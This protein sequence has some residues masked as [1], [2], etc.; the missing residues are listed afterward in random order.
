MSFLKSRVNLFSFFLSSLVLP[1]CSA[2]RAWLSPFDR[3]RVRMRWLTPSSWISFKTEQAYHAWP[4]FTRQVLQNQ[5]T[6]KFSIP[7]PIVTH[8]AKGETFSCSVLASEQYSALGLSHPLACTGKVMESHSLE[9]EIGA[10]ECFSNAAGN[11]EEICQFS[12]KMSGQ[13]SSKNR[14]SQRRILFILLR[15]EA[16]LLFVWDIKKANTC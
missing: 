12:N 5:V 7:F 15:L 4:L 6:Y 10:W 2:V 13:L 16:C 11:W 1:L 8:F 3:L 9:T 14:T